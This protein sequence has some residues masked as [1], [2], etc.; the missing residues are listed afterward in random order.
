M[1]HS[2][3]RILTTH[4]GRLQ[5]PDPL[6]ARMEGDYR[7][8]GDPEF[9]TMLRDDV[10][11]VVAQQAATGID[12]VCDGEFGRPSWNNYLHTRLAGH[13]IVPDDT[14]HAVQSR[15]RTAFASYYEEIERRG[16]RYY[17]APG[18]DLPGGQRWACTG[19]VSYVGQDKLQQDL[20]NLRVAVDAAGVE[21]AFMTST[22][23]IRPG[24]NAFYVTEEEYY[25]AVGEAM[26]TEYRA[27]IDA[28]FLVQIDDPHLPDMWD[29]IIGSMREDATDVG[30]YLRT[31]ERHVEIINHALR[32][33]PSDRIRYHMCWG[34]WH[35]PHSTD[36]ELKDL[37]GVL[38]KVAAG[39]F[40]I[41][42]ANARHEHEWMVWRDVKLPDDKILAAG[43]VSHA[44]NTLEHPDLVAWRLQNFASVVGRER[45]VAST[46][47]GL[48]YRVHPQIAWAKLASVVEG[49]RRASNAL[50]P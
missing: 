9:L 26:R 10:R 23:P 4:V 37:V 22:S 3:G 49:A 33:L 19:P 12:I 44:T 18:G 11:D 50:W 39:C 14:Q 21:E 41:E 25:A 32:G 34:S 38:N 8:P 47:C 6:S 36:I 15:D 30:A 2:Q 31:A 27:I 46:D 45:V 48:G 7:R 28:G 35:G 29:N 42:A 20:A 43:V 16:L 5:R 17:A 13:E 24:H 1:K 40:V